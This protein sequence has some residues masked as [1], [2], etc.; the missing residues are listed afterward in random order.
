MRSALF[1]VLSLLMWSGCANPPGGPE[2]ARQVVLQHIGNGVGTVGPFNRRDKA[3]LASLSPQDRSTAV[4]LLDRGAVGFLVFGPDNGT[5][6]HAANGKLAD[7]ITV[8]R[9]LFV[10]NGQIVGDF[11]AVKK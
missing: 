7:L 3:E 6:V 10:Q 8:D 1:V 5:A 2:A 11:L 4:A 9:I